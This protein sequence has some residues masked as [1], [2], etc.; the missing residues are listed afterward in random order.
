M[1]S[2]MQACR[3]FFGM[4]DGQTALDFG[5]EVHALSPK[6]R[7]EI[8]QGLRAIGFDIDKATIEKSTKAAA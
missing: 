6:D 7:I 8:A 4:K 5:R 2:F 3:E 1:V